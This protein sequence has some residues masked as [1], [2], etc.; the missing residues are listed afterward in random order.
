[1]PRHVGNSVRCLFLLLDPVQMRAGAQE[2]GLSRYG[3]GGHH[4][5]VESA[6]GQDLQ[7]GAAGR[8]GEDCGVTDRREGIVVYA[9]CGYAALIDE[10]SGAP[11]DDPTLRASREIAT[12]R[13]P[14]AGPPPPNTIMPVANLL[15][16]RL[17][18]QVV[19]S[20]NR[21]WRAEHIAAGMGEY[22]RQFD[23]LKHSL[24]NLSVRHA[25]G[26]GRRE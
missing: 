8:G 21:R 26:N 10:L 15:Q 23:T 20:Q 13:H 19:N 16:A 14:L 9:S 11:A 12:P 3:G 18:T 24:R 2:E 17:Y 22:A 25:T 6:D 7:P 4:L 1:M 5:V